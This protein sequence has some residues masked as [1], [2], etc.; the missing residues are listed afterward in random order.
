M[1]TFIGLDFDDRLKEELYEIQK[2]IRTSSQKGSWVPLPNFHITLKF[3]GDTNENQVDEIDKII[4][5]IAVNNLPILITLDKLG[6]FNKKNNQYGVIWIGIKGEI[7]KI[8]T[9]YDIIER[10]MQTIG[11][12]MEKRKFTPHI[13]LGRRI[14]LDRPFNKLV[15]YANPKLGNEF[16]WIIYLL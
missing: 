4:E 5:S 10:E 6:Y 12:P 13:T 1:R 3:L 8:N 16:Y 9:I 7:M 11:F 15:E 2:N 14:K